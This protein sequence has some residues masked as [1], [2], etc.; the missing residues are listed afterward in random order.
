MSGDKKECGAKSKVLGGE[1][2]VAD[3]MAEHT[4]ETGHERYQRTFQDYA[5]VKKAEQ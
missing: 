4:K 3:W 2:A 1:Q 5:L